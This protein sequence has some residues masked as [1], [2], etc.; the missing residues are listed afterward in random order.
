[1]RVGRRGQQQ[2]GAVRRAAGDDD[3][4]AGERLALAVALHH[5][6]GDRRARGVRSPAVTASAFVS[7]VT[8]SCSSAGRTP[9]TSASDF[10]CTRHGKPSHVA[11]RTQAL[12]GMS[13]SASI[14]PHGAWNGWRPS[15]A[16]SSESCWMRGSWLT[17]GNGYGALLRRLG[18]VLPTC[19]VHVV[20]LLGLRVVRLELVVGDRPRGRH[21][22][23]VAQLAEVLGPQPVQR[24]AVE[25]RRAADEVVHLR[26]ERLAVGVVP[27][28]LGDVAV[29]DEHVVGGPVGR[30]AREPVTAL[31]EQDAL[32]GRRQVA[33][34]G[35]AAGAAADHDDVVAS[36]C[37]L[38]QS[39]G[40]D[41]AAP[42]PR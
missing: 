14:T 24:R 13:S 5:D 35:P 36:S 20:E 26:L 6:A 37:Q 4:V 18:R 32:A 33:H 21:A 40:E 19:A 31:E 34:E 12:W 42:P 11:Q 23:V 22:V 15:A 27:G 7:S 3:E 25:L 2:L 16:R 30:L 10:A 1:M 39:F 29:V 41:D 8:L 38:R 9:S 17:A 28:V